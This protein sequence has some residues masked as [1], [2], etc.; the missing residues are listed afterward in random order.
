M[1]D[2]YY[3]T[4]YQEKSSN[5]LYI[6]DAYHGLFKLN[7][8]QHTADHL[9]HPH[10]PIVIP[11]K[12]N[13]KDSTQIIKTMLLSEIDTTSSASINPF[14]EIEHH[15]SEYDPMILYPPKFYNDLDISSD[16]RVIIFTDSSYKYTRS[17]NR[18]EI[19]DGAPRGRVF[20]YVI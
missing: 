11:S 20:K 17:E 8:L 12:N 6:L 9:L 7:L 18:Q 4:Y 14:S 15:L 19:L 5:F 16:G 3:T 13:N 1:F 10:S 2:I